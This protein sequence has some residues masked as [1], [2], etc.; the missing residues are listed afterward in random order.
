[1]TT[2]MRSGNTGKVRCEI[3]FSTRSLRKQ[4]NQFS[5]EFAQLRGQRSRFIICSFSLNKRQNIMPVYD[6]VI[7]EDGSSVEMKKRTKDM[8]TRVAKVNLF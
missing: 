6:D 8:K 2:V 5:V 4:F 7:Q 3:V 1:M